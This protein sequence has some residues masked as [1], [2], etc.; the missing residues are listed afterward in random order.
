MTLLFRPLK[1]RREYRTV[2][3]VIAL[4]KGN[5]KE[6][7]NS[8]SIETIIRSC[9]YR[10]IATIGVAGVCFF[11]LVFAALCPAQD[12]KA[13]DLEELFPRQS[14]YSTEP[15]DDNIDFVPTNYWGHDPV[16]IVKS[17]STTPF[18]TSGIRYDRDSPQYLEAVE[19]RAGLLQN[20][21]LFGTV[22]FGSRLAYVF[23]NDSENSD[24]S[25]ESVSCEYNPSNRVLTVRRSFRNPSCVGVGFAN[26]NPLYKL[27]AGSYPH[28]AVYFS[29]FSREEQTYALA[30]EFSQLRKKSQV[31]IDHWT[32]IDVSPQEYDRFKDSI[33][34]I[35]AFSI[36]AG[37]NRYIG[38]FKPA[39]HQIVTYKDLPFNLICAANPE[40][41]LYDGKTGEIIAKYTAAETYN[42][43]RVKMMKTKVSLSRNKESFNDKTGSDEEVSVSTKTAAQ[44][45]RD[46]LKTA[47][48]VRENW[49]KKTPSVIIPDD[50][51]TLEEALNKTK[52]GDV[53]QIRKGATISLKEGRRTRSESAEVVIDHAV[54]IIGETG[55]PRD[56]SLQIGGDESLKIESGGNVSTKGV[57]FV[58]SKPA[59]GA[60]PKPAVV[61]GNDAKATFRDCVFS[62]AKVKESVGV[63]V[64]GEFAEAEFWKCEFR[65][66]E[67]D[68]LRVDL[69]A[70]AKVEYCQFLSGNRHGISSFNSAKVDVGKSRFDG[71][72]T[73]FQADG[74]GGVVVTNS[75]FSNNR[76]NW[77]VSPG[78]RLACDT[79]E[80]NVIEK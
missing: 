16:A 72:V 26:P 37:G 3:V 65:S 44:S 27:A 35:C 2:I 80:G 20:E 58:S 19:Y 10:F 11:T 50:C 46:V 69:S 23:P 73:G 31:Q 62:G 76:S 38:F 32:I 33:R 66:F 6:V 67:Q 77:S 21:S 79:K 36:G 34:V 47:E 1:L 53:I 25:M 52:D 9:L 61:V 57:S 24:T 55:A 48:D 78:S 71:N 18:S 39:L 4:S 63:V 54:A 40:F 51:K 41:W 70:K 42:G 14:K 45:W 13:P 29:L 56:V 7:M 28:E 59:V 75:F 22:K 30:L 5:E 43:K 74:G 17:L 64:E 60:A 12:D 8:F 68:A 15:F 49:E